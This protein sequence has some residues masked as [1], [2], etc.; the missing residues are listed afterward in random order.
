MAKPP[1]TPL[2]PLNKELAETKDAIFDT[3]VKLKIGT[4]DV[5]WNGGGDS[6][7]VE[8]VVAKDEKQDVEVELDNHEIEIK[9]RNENLVKTGKSYKTVVTFTKETKKLNDAIESFCMD[10][11][12]SKGS[13]GWYNDD[14]GFGS[15]QFD[16][17]KREISIDHENNETISNS[18]GAEVV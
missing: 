5:M 3:L 6:G 12:D 14:G 8:S 10:W 1:K 16:V 11:V 2:S 7:G 18:I 13:S 15:A 9:V 4:V 17:A